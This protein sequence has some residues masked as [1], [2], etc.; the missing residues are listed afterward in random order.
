ME[1][2]LDVIGGQMETP[3]PLAVERRETAFFGRSVPRFLPGLNILLPNGKT[4]IPVLE[5]FCEWGNGY[6]G[7]EC[8][9]GKMREQKPLRGF[10]SDC[11]LSA[12]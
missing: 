5:A 4:V 2:T 9:L 1:A 3:Y 7:R 11:F 8:I 10:H 12:D 6:L